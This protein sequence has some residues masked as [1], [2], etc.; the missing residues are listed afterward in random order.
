MIKWD[1][2]LIYCLILLINELFALLSPQVLCKNTMH[3]N[4]S[5]LTNRKLK[6]RLLPLSRSL[7]SSNI[8]LSRLSFSFSSSSL[9]L[10]SLSAR[11]L[12]SS[13]W[14]SVLLMFSPCF[15]LFW[16][17]PLCFST[18]ASLLLCTDKV[19]EKKIQ[20]S[21]GISCSSQFSEKISSFKA[22]G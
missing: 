2:K 7:C 10:S 16:S 3:L 19:L 17:T 18:G 21:K 13:L 1:C 11:S 22:P 9:P 14:M 12:S 6:Q 5:A 8:S 4:L 20:M 15:S